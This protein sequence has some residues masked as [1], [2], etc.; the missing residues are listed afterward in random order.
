MIRKNIL[1]LANIFRKLAFSNIHAP[2]KLGN[3]SQIF[4][5]V[6]FHFKNLTGVK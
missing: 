1:K 2:E 3:F 4:T 5:I 6:D